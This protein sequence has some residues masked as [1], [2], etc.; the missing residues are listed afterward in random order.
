MFGS[1]EDRENE[2]LQS[3]TEVL[4]PL[5]QRLLAYWE[6]RASFVDPDGNLLDN[7]IKEGIS[8]PLYELIALYSPHDMSSVEAASFE[9]FLHLMLQFN[10]ED[11]ATAK[12]LLQ[13]SWLV[14]Q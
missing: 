7:I 14:K 5:P 12:D 1:E 9:E 10:P 6:R 4:G 13:H 3:M 2:L 8:E 11:R